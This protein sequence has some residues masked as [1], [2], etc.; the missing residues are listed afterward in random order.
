MISIRI[1]D[2][3]KYTNSYREMVK[4]FS[5]QLPTQELREK[6]ILSVAEEDILLAAEC[7]T[8]SAE[9]E[10]ILQQKLITKIKDEI[11]KYKSI[12]TL[13][14]HVQASINLNN[15]EMIDL[16]L[17]KITFK[18]IQYFPIILPKILEKM[19][20]SQIIAFLNSISLLEKEAVLNKI[21]IDILRIILIKRINFSNEELESLR[22]ILS[23]NKK[24]IRISQISNFLNIKNEFI[25]NTL[26]EINPNILTVNN[27]LRYSDIIYI[28]KYSNK[29]LK[30]NN[31][32]LDL[33]KK[34]TLVNLK[35]KI[36][37]NVIYFSYSKI[38]KKEILNKFSKLRMSFD[39]EYDFLYNL[40]ES[41]FDTINHKK[42]FKSNYKVFIKYL[43]EINV[44]SFKDNKYSFN[45]KIKPEH[46]P[47]FLE[48]KDYQIE[49]RKNM[50]NIIRKTIKNKDKGKEFMIKDFLIKITSGF[51]KKWLKNIIYL[52]ENLIT[53][54]LF[55]N[56]II[57]YIDIDKIKLVQI[58]NNEIWL[59]ILSE[60]VIVN[61]LLNCIV[62]KIK[63]NKLIVEI[64]DLEKEAYIKI[65]EL[66]HRNIENITNFEYN[67]E[68]L[69][70]GQKIIA[71]VINVDKQGRINLSLKQI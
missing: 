60:L 45:L 43:R 62:T 69:H 27:E 53:N 46:I 65:H 71:K 22:K 38:V 54:F 51:D 21:Q 70:I 35:Y 61:D 8:S 56:S 4:L 19:N 52:N 20:N 68:K 25:V 32:S 10:E 58:P 50:T 12:I 13:I 11:E 29:I 17:S 36:D 48:S 55:Q 37:N 18:D 64:E 31:E 49:F 41:C 40:Y 1:F 26:S 30:Y 16:F 44:L 34:L 42:Q 67:G 24:T 47:I 28:I 23:N 9:I 57:E 2:N 14:E 66:S 63:H 39:Y 7:K 6:F 59:K 5:T 3:I 33:E 15:F